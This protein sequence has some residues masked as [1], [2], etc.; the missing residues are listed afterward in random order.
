MY[1]CC[2]TTF[3]SEFFRRREGDPL[4]LEQNHLEAPSHR[5][6]VCSL[7]TQPLTVD[8]LQVLPGDTRMAGSPLE[9]EDRVPHQDSQA[10][11]LLEG[12]H[13]QGNLMEGS[14]VLQDNPGSLQQKEGPH[15]DNHQEILALHS[16]EQDHQGLTGNL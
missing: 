9:G 2:C 4:V 10:Q 13:F 14:L 1:S 6:E 5:Q 12:L 3:P 11:A 7:D 16:Q 8:I 15:L